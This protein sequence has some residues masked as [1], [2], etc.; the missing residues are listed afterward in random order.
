MGELGELRWRR[1]PWGLLGM[2]VLVWAVESRIAR[3]Q[4]AFLDTT[5][6]TWATTARALRRHAAQSEILMFGDSLSEYGL[7]PKVIEQKTGK[8]GYNFAVSAASS[9]IS[10]FLF[11]DAVRAGAKPAAVLIDYEPNILVQPSLVAPEWWAELICLQDVVELAWC[12]RDAG[13]LTRFVVA[14]CLPSE[15]YR[16]TIRSALLDGLAEKR[17]AGAEVAPALRVLA[18]Q[19]RGA[20]VLAHTQREPALV[21]FNNETFFPPR[22]RCDRVNRRYIE[23]FFEL[24]SAHRIPVFWVVPPYTPAIQAGRERLGQDAE[25]SRFIATM[26][27]QFPGVTVLD[28]RRSAYDPSVFWDGYVHLDGLGAR[29]LSVDVAVAMQRTLAGTNPSPW[30]HLPKYRD[31]GEDLVPLNGEDRSIATRPNAPLTR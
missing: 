13:F 20:L 4:L 29:A 30:V 26:R 23:K 7:M 8:S 25:L 9:P 11:R 6:V 14:A 5:S 28:A 21:A 1:C 15:R 3:G 10:F 19:N 27:S 12:G 17:R 18:R 24:A 22:W 2:M 16:Y 31:L